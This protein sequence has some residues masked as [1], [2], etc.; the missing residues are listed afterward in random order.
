MWVVVDCV[1]VKQSSEIPI[2]KIHEA[3]RPTVASSS[4]SVAASS[5]GG[6]LAAA[7]AAAS[8]PV[9]RNPQFGSLWVGGI[10]ARKDQKLTFAAKSAEVQKGAED[11]ASSHKCTNQ[12]AQQHSPYV[13]EHAHNLVDCYPWGEDA[14]TKAQAEYKSIFLSGIS[15]LVCL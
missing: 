8:G 2:S 15:C 7:A 3:T 12:L 1:L 11:M 6:N 5:G 4:S 9:S 13:L 10:L 14:F